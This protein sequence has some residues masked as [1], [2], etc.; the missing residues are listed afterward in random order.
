MDGTAVHRTIRDQFNAC[1]TAKDTRTYRRFDNNFHSTEV[2]GFIIKIDMET[3]SYSYSF[4]TLARQAILSSL[5]SNPITPLAQP[6]AWIRIETASSKAVHT[7]ASIQ[8]K[9][10]VISQARL[11][12]H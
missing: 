8:A 5:S 4:F 11:C 7:S 1:G 6:A 9:N 3:I 10:R 12:L 2:D